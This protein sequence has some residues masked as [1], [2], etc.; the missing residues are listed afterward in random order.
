MRDS[1][2]TSFHLAC[3]RVV[4]ALRTGNK[5]MLLGNGGSAA[6]AQ[7]VAAE[8]VGRFRLERRPWPALALSENVSSLTGIANDYAYELV[9]VRQLEAF[10][11]AGD[12]LIAL[13]TSGQSASVVRALECAERLGITSIA[14]TG[15]SPNRAA[16]LADV[17]LCVP[18]PTTA[19]I[20]EGYMLVLHAMCHF[21]E[22]TLAGL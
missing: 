9:F 6:D 14:L 22:E 17:A 10:A 18:A 20:Q 15:P 5:L 7:H 19:S 11:R 12:V 13:S 3:D 21:C 16:E 2:Q 8:F 4:A 1:L